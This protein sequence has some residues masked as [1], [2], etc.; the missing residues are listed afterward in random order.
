MPR[1]PTGN[2]DIN[3]FNH[4]KGHH[5]SKNWKRGVCGLDYLGSVVQLP[6]GGRG[7]PPTRNLVGKGWRRRVLGAAGT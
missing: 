2:Q 7:L 1:N 3:K 5:L 6:P 4:W